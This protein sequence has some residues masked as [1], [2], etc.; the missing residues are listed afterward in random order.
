MEFA[1]ESRSQMLE[2]FGACLRPD[3]SLL[4]C[5]APPLGLDVQALVIDDFV[6][7]GALPRGVSASASLAAQL[8]ERAQ[9]AY[10]SEQVAAS[11]EKDV[12]GAVRFQAVGAELDSSDHCL[13]EGIV[14]CAAPLSRRIPLAC[15]SLRAAALP[16][17]SPSFCARFAGAGVAVLLYRRC[18]M[19]LFSE[20][21]QL[22]HLR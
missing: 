9:R 20:V 15:L 13:S 3:L 19:V 16:V 11:P 1:L 7:V 22:A 17:A 4:N 21:F 8:H 6:C 18:I 5:L 12:L 2:Y 14:P 10:F